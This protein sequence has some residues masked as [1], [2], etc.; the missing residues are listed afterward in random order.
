[1]LR[2][3]FRAALVGWALLALLVTA[4]PASAQVNTGSANFTTYVAVG[5]SLTA[6]FMSGGLMDRAQVN[7]YP[8]LIYRQATGR[9]TGFEQPLVSSPGI[10]ALLELR[11]LVPL[12]IGQPSGTG[13]PLNLTLQRPYNNMA[14]PGADVHD[15]LAT[16]SSCAV[17][18]PSSS[19]R[20]RC[21]RPSSLCGSATTTRWRPPRRASSTTRR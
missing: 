2:N 12:S 3:T 17:W 19:R 14:V 18:A 8:A 11:S 16:T 13:Q 5:D 9:T 6:G 20:W 4:L 15:V 1:M 21:T 10:P 7:S